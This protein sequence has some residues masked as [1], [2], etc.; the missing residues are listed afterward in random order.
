MQSS[1]DSQSLGT[2][3]TLKILHEI[4]YKSPS[5]LPFPLTLA[6]LLRDLSYVC[7]CCFELDFTC[8]QITLL[9]DPTI[10]VD[11]GR[12]ANICIPTSFSL[13]APVHRAV[14]PKSQPH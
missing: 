1:V 4:E 7:F 12:P 14:Y 2:R 9:L 8:S 13:M 3:W 11:G 6:L 5:L 10:S